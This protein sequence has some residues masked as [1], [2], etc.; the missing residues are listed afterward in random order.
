V[1]ARL[2]EAGVEEITVRPDEGVFSKA[3]VECLESLQVHFLLKVPD[4]HWV[5]REL[6]PMRRSAESPEI[7]KDPALRMWSAGGT[8]YGARFLSLEWRRT[9]PG[10]D[11]LFDRV[12][13]TQRSHVLTNLRDIHALTASGGPTTTAPPW[14]QR[15]KE[16]PQLGAG[17]T[18][19]DGLGGNALP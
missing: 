3:M 6:G 19:V 17:R 12:R 5:R 9:E 4:H 11:E 16:L 14:S 13:I 8:L 10:P 2:R 18:A 15:I 7:T 1:V